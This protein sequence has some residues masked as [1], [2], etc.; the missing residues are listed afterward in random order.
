M[1]VMTAVAE[2]LSAL[3]LNPDPMLA[4]FR[5]EQEQADLQFRLDQERRDQAF[6]LSLVDL[7]R[8]TQLEQTRSRYLGMLLE[9]LSNNSERSSQ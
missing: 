3:K 9:S 2:G 4:R 5:I 6:R 1:S 7:N 8:R